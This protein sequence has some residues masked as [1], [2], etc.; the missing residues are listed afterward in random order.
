MKLETQLT[1]LMRRSSSISC[2]RLL[3]LLYIFEERCRSSIE[4]G[5]QDYNG[6]SLDDI[7]LILQYSFPGLAPGFLFALSKND[8]L[9]RSPD[10]GFSWKMVYNQESD[11]ASHVAE[12]DM[13]TTDDF[14]KNLIKGLSSEDADLDVMLSN[15]EK[16]HSTL[17]CVS[18]YSESVALAGK[19]GFLALSTDRG[20]TFTTSKSYLKPILGSD[21]DVSYLAIVDNNCILAAGGSTVCKVAI[22]PTAFNKAS[23]SEATVI[24][25]CK[26]YVCTLEVVRYSLTSFQIIVAEAGWL[27]LSWNN[28]SDF[29]SVP[30]K[31]GCV[32]SLDS[33]SALRNCE[34]PPFPA[35]SLEAYLRRSKSTSFAERCQES[36]EYSCGTT[37]KD[38]SSFALE[39]LKMALDASF[40]RFGRRNGIFFRSFLVMG[41]GTEVLSYDYTS[42]LCLCISASGDCVTVF[43]HASSVSYVPFVRSSLDDPMF[44]LSTIIAPDRVLF[45][46]ACSCGAS[47][48]WDMKKWSDPQVSDPVGFFALDGNELIVCNEQNVIFVLHC[49]ESTKV[50]S[51]IVSGSFRVHSLKRASIL[52]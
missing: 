3:F 35:N 18:S 37:V 41:N 33:L 30:H 44:C 39:E 43:S 42:V 6:L 10:R 9:L 32:R 40:R 16:D 48:S 21:C 36:Y 52:Y 2:D 13:N 12:E 24:L 45:A 22:T 17:S 28:G 14:L 29:V 50:S 26:S 15:H 46:R 1:G 7:V 38:F 51:H 4:S 19:G 49:N 47:I 31:L 11:S 20:V 23:F 25:K 27:H 34:M 8:S 5:H